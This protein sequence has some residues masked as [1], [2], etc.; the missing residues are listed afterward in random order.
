MKRFDIVVPREFK[1]SDGTTGK[2]FFKIGAAF[3]M[4]EREGYSIMLDAL[5]V[6]GPDGV[7][8]LMF[9]ADEN[10]GQREPEKRHSRPSKNSDDDSDIPF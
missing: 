6:P 5:P 8:L 10:R 7:K 2:S 3:P 1:K 9:V 4:R